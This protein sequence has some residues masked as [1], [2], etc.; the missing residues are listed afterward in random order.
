MMS[1]NVQ[2]SNRGPVI[3]DD[4]IASAKANQLK[5]RELNSLDITGQINET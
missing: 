4:I 3:I 1:P 5:N 2:V